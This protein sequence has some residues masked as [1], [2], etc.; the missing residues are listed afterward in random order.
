VI[1]VLRTLAIS[2][3]NGAPKGIASICSSHPIVIRAA[4]REAARAGQPLLLEA[5]CNQ[6]NQFG[7]YTG[8]QPADF[9][10]M[11]ID[12]ARDEGLPAEAVILGGDHLGPNPWRKESAP[13]AML[14]A[15]QMVAAYARAGFRKIHLD[16]SMGCAGEPA[17]LGDAVIAD[18][19]ARLAK[20]AERAAAASGCAPP[21]YVIGTEVPPAGGAHHAIAGI[22][23]TSLAAVQETIEVHREVFRRHGRSD[24]F[25]RVIAIVVQP[26][27]E[28]GNENVVV[29]NRTKARH[30][31]SLLADEP[32]LVYEAHSTDYQGR[33]ALRE[34]VED[35]FAILKV[36]PE[37]TFALR[38]ALYG[39][40]LIASDLLPDYGA[41]PLYAAMEE[42][43]LDNPSH[44][45][46]H[47][48]GPPGAQRLERHYS[49]SDRIRY[50]WGEPRAAAAVKRLTANLTGKI[51]PVTLFRQHLPAFEEFAG[52]PLN[53]VE[54]VIC[55]IRRS[56]ENYRFAACGETV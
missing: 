20:E 5:T 39:L 1:Q 15:E 25:S 45:K 31:A 18:R 30:L 22:E 44:W 21:L 13:A 3:R 43:M 4:A 36:G 34:L 10:R 52:K 9:V 26:G 49:F 41:R 33:V 29:Y 2:R 28:F 54:V 19:A 48:S 46:S 12:I 32:G 27:V 42:A 23:P 16:A 47:Y 6:V 11:A 37:L 8:M 7:G 17:I 40:D 24:A 56:L 55:A 35:G 53:P 51:A 14:K 38:E 50:Y